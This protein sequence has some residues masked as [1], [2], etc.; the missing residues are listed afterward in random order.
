MFTCKHNIHSPS[1]PTP[2]SPPGDSGSVSGFTSTGTPR[3]PERTSCSTQYGG[4]FFAASK[5]T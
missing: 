1:D 2:Y 3:L 4:K 5:M